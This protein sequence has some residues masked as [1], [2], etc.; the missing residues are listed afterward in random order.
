M[1]R[2]VVI[3]GMGCVSGLGIGVE[4]TWQRL[5]AGECGIRPL[6]RP[7]MEGPAAFAEKRV[8]DF[9]GA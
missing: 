9:K 7:P 3:T 4:R 6:D 8:P 1:S 2:K 5:S